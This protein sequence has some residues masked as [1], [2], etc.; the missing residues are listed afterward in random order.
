MEHKHGSWEDDFSLQLCDFWVPFAV[1]FQGFSAINA[2][3]SP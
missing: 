3:V 2:A 1:N